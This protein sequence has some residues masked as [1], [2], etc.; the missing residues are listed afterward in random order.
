MRMHP[1]PGDDHDR[2][3]PGIEIGGEVKDVLLDAAER[4]AALVD[5]SDPDGLTACEARVRSAHGTLLPS[6]R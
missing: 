5:E 6:S 1:G 3:K 2:R 4:P